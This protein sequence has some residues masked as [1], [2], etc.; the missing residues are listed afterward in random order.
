MKAALL[1]PR[2]EKGGPGTRCWLLALVLSP[3]GPVQREN[4][5]VL[6]P[7][8]LSENEEVLSE[9]I[10]FLGNITPDINLDGV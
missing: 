3:P 10:G 7:A 5:S 4:Q 9:E 1:S 8:P 6:V 2:G